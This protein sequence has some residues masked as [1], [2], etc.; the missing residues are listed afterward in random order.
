[1]SPFSPLIERATELAA[2]W[3]SGTYRKSRWR[4]PPFLVEGEA[5]RIPVMSHLTMV[6][7]T[8]Q[9]AG[10]G[11]VTVAAA[12]LHDILE[13]QSSAGERMDPSVLVEEVGVEVATLVQ[14]VTEPKQSAEGRR[15]AWEHRKQAY[16]AQLR[17]A[18]PE[19]AAISLAD[20][21]HNLWSMNQALE[22]DINIFSG[23][24]RHPGLGGDASKQR[25]FH[26][27]VLEATQSHEDER[28]PPMQS[29]LRREL[30]RFERLS[31]PYRN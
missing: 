31:Q 13:D 23:D 4:A 26:K 7:M 1:M 19:A 29:Q 25:W 24:E 2:E 18:P 21:Q 17:A 28:L 16:V 14:H 12:L 27:A 10:W 11:E 15:L 9:R 6:A 8:V 5:G 3:H 22:I 20:K 30:D